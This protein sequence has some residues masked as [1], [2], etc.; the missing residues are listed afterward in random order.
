MRVE[1]LCTR[2]GQG[3][4][5]EFLHL[6]ART[7]NRL[8][9]KPDGTITITKKKAN[10]FSTNTYT[11]RSSFF[12]ELS[13]F[14]IFHRELHISNNEKKNHQQG[15]ENTICEKT[16]MKVYLIGFNYIFL[17]IT[18]LDLSI[19]RGIFIACMWR[20][21]LKKTKKNVGYSGEFICCD[22]AHN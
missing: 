7:V 8:E 13:T 20:V 15:L 9:I 4:D 6:L 22:V 3:F 21:L 14:S 2:T 1:H 12:R 5:I 17:C 10:P 19:P 11:S 16:F 18:P